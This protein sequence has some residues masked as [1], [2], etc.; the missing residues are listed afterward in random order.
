MSSPRAALG[1]TLV[2]L[3]SVFFGVCGPFGKVVIQSGLEP[4]QVTWLRIAGVGLIAA[5]AAAWPLLRLRRGGPKPPLAD[6]K[7]VV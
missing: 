6:R 1:V 5:A 4:V 3:A 7:S 2:L